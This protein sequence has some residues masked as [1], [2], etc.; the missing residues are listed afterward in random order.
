MPGTTKLIARLIRIVGAK[1]DCIGLMPRA[2]RMTTPAPIRPKTAPEA[3]TVPCSGL[4]IR[5][6]PSAPVSSDVK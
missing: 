2:C 1:P 4:D 3:P 5:I 6:A